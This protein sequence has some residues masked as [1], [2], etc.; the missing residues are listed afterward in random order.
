MRVRI[1]DNVFF[2][3]SSGTR[4]YRY[5]TLTQGNLRSNTKKGFNKVKKIF[6]FNVYLKLDLKRNYF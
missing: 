5:E 2:Y 1:Y 3:L 4:L 6:I